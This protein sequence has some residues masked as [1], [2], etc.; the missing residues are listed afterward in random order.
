MKKITKLSNLFE[1]APSLLKEWH[2]TANGDLTPRRVILAYPEKLWWICREGHEWQATIK[3][4]LKRK[5]CPICEKED[6]KKKVDLSFDLQSTGKNNRK[7][8]RFKTKTTAVI[9]VPDSGHW[10]YAEMTDFSKN[11]LC[12]ETQASIQ[13][14]T[15]IRVKFDK[16]LVSSR[17]DKSIKSLSNDGYKTY[18]STVKWC[19]QIDDDQAI[20]NFGI[21]VALI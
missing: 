7:N 9:E 19:K 15:L 3:C 14:G 16:T 5:D 11:G 6:A 1:I 20:S 21:G 8:R 17:F 18:N 13:P 10:V 2:P 4:K 12:F